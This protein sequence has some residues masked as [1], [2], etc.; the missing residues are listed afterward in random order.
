MVEEKKKR[1]IFLVLASDRP[2]NVKDEDIQRSTWFTKVNQ[3]S[4][5]LWLRGKTGI[6]PNIKGHTLWVPCDDS[7]IL[8]KTILGISFLTSLYSFDFLVRSNVS[9]YFF[10]PQFT[11]EIS[12]FTTKDFIAGYPEQTGKGNEPFAAQRFVSGAAICMPELTAR[13]LLNLDLDFYRGWPDDVAIS[14]YLAK[15]GSKIIHIKR[16]NLSY[17]H[18]VIINS[19]VRCKSSEKPNLAHQ[20]MMRL[21]SIEVAKSKKDLLIVLLKLQAFEI[22]NCTYTTQ[23][24]LSYLHRI[25]NCLKTYFRVILQTHD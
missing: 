5:V 18:M 7:Q 1:F 3:D 11:K 16:S 22:R 9:T 2:E 19:Y 24:L 6:K 15:A 12:R 25:Y 13:A 23:N 8:E 21:H 17:H 4:L 10:L 14:H 20:R